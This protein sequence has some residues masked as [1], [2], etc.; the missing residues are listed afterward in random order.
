MNIKVKGIPFTLEEVISYELIPDNVGEFH[1]ACQ[2]RIEEEKYVSSGWEN[3][4]DE[5]Q[6]EMATLEDTI[7]DLKATIIELENR[8]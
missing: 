8:Q 4:F 3:D 7:E 6:A 2:D 5:A 1:D